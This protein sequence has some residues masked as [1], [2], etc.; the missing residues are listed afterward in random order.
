MPKLLYMVLCESVIINAEDNVTSLINL[1]EGLT[2]MTSDAIPE[3]AELPQRWG[4][5]SMWRR[6]EPEGEQGFVQKF[7]MISPKGRAFKET[8][9]PFK[10][11]QG[12]YNHKVKL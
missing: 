5:Y 11:S 9:T 8:E 3:D 6:E 2:L 4:V 10:F 12:K 1:L 7:V